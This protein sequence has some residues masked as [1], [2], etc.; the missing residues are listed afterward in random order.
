MCKEVFD[1]SDYIYQ[2]KWDGVRML[3]YINK[4]QVKLINKRQ[5]LRTEQY[6]E[7]MLLPKLFKGHNSIIDGEIV[8]VRNGKP[9]FPA[10]IRRDRC[11]TKSTINHLKESLP[12]D[13]M[14]FD[15]VFL[16][17]RDLTGLPFSER[18]EILSQVFSFDKGIHL[19]DDFTQGTL[20]YSAVKSQ[21]L[22][23]IIAKKKTSPY[24]EGKKH[25]AWFKIKYRHQ[26]LCVIGGFTKSNKQI[27]SLLLGVYQAGNLYY[28]GKVGSGLTGTEWETLSIKLP[29]LKSNSSPFYNLK[30]NK[31]DY[32]YIKPVLPV[33]IEFAE[34]TDNMHLRS[35][36]I[37]HFVN[38]DPQ[39]CY[40]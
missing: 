8:V 16:N 34:W 4:N 31:P 27:N 36:V 22:E 13:Y 7:L 24:I 21:E 25:K 10:V 40:V 37:K 6:P 11:Q 15:L 1:S 26:Q 17:D 14:V 5:H 32:F 29:E 2:L 39:E 9:S 3:T 38:I 12:I 33:L 30:Y 19:V 23:G 18:K 20:L 28:V 35:P